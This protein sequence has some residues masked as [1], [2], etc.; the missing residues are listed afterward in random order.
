MHKVL[1]HKVLQAAF[2]ALLVTGMSQASHAQMIGDENTSITG[3][4]IY[5]EEDNVV[6][7]QASHN[8]LTISGAVGL[9]LNPTA[10]IPAKGGARVQANYFDLFNAQTTDASLFGLYAATRVGDA[11]LEVSVGIAKL[12][13]DNDILDI[14]KTGF[15][16]GA[17]YLVTGD[18]NTDP[19]AVRVAVGAGYDSALYKNTHAYVV[20]TKAFSAGTRVVTGHLGA[21]FDRFSL[22]GL[23]LNSSKVSFYGGLEVPID[24]RGHFNLVGELGTKNATAELGGTSPYSVSLRYQNAGGF[25]ASAGIARQGV[26]AD[27]TN[28]KNGG[29]RFFAQVGQTF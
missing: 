6:Y 12:N 22:S 17:K 14:D 20:A 16:I 7:E 29:G 13:S 26:V 23:D 15:T 21:R 4:T 10:H 27:F 28:D 1:S 9:P 18:E 2:A 24:S 11:P 25:A 3:N 5:V 19:E 8:G